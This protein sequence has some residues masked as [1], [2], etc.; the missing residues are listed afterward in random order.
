M[1]RGSWEWS[2]EYLPTTPLLGHGHGRQSLSLR[3]LIGIKGLISPPPP[4]H[5]LSLSFSFFSFFFLVYFNSCVFFIISSSRFTR[6]WAFSLKRLSL[7]ISLLFG[8]LWDFVG[9]WIGQAGY[10][11]TKAQKFG[12]I[13]V[14][15][16]YIFGIL[17]NRF[18][19]NH[20]P[21]YHIIS[22]VLIEWLIKQV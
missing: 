4:K 11:D 3:I 12:V 7:F 13:V 9:F 20:K 8:I 15:I 2:V 18:Q 5:G 1:Y 22:G 21:D 17:S 6:L 19:Y 14:A 16:S 10:L